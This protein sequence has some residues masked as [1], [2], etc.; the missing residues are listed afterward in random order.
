MSIMVN[1]ML[2]GW[3]VVALVFFSLLPPRR[4]VLMTV[5]GGWL[6]L[7][8][9]AVYPGPFP[10]YGKFEA[11]VLPTLLMGVLFDGQR[12]AQ[13][14]WRWPENALQQQENNKDRRATH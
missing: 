1:I 14:R 2:L 4:A 11:V 9:D 6:F 3:A 10:Q 5:I 12:F 13:L 8:V 7:P